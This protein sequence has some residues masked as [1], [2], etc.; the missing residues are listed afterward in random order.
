MANPAFKRAASAANSNS[1]SITIDAGDFVCVFCV[2][3]DNT[4]PSGIQDSAGNIFG[5][6]QSFTQ[7]NPVG[8]MTAVFYK[9]IS[10]ATSVSFTTGH[11]PSIAVVTFSNANN[12]R[13]ASNFGGSS[14]NPLPSSSFNTSLAN[15]YGL[16]FGAFINTGAS[17][18]ISSTTGGTNQ[19]SQNST[20][21]V[22]GIVAVTSSALIAT[23]GTNFNPQVNLSGSAST[24][25]VM[26]QIENGALTGMCPNESP[27]PT[28]AYIALKYTAG[29]KIT[30]G[31]SG[32]ATPVPVAA[33]LK[34]GTTG[35]AYSETIS[36][37]G[38]SGTG[39]TF[40]LTAG[41]LPTG[42]SL[43]SSTGIISGTASTAGTFTFTIKVTDSSGATGTQSFSITIAAPSSSGGGNYTF[44][45]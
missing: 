3:K 22:D 7:A 9:A 21:A 35:V 45:G 25:G 40:A 33:V 27:I 42:T 26:V 36:A 37:Q 18:S 20:T 17:L 44:V 29:P 13:Y 4:A 38:G 10:A 1:V 8:Q 16:L 2:N 5:I 23:A 39:Y 32:P 30:G 12:A 41:A 28:P 15:V 6:F 19:T 31:S 34:G 11:T 24:I 14:N 43:A